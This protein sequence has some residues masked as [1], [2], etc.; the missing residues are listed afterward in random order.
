MIKIIINDIVW[1]RYSKF[2]TPN[3]KTKLIYLQVN[4]IEEEFVSKLVFKRN[5]RRLKSIENVI[6]Y[7]SVEIQTYT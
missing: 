2:L 1:I 4:K 5:G 7:I 6:N 3:T